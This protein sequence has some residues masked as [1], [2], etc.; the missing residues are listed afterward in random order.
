MKKQLLLLLVMGLFT[1]SA[2]AGPTVTTVNG[3]GIWQSGSGGEF[4]LAFTGFNPLSLYADV[5]KNQGSIPAGSP[6]T[7]Q[8]F[9]LEWNEHINA[10]T[11][12]DVVFNDRA[13]NGGV[14]PPGD[15]ISVGTA[16]LY[17]EF[18]NGTLS[19]YDY[20]TDAG[21]H[22]SADA[23]QKA[24]WYLEGETGGSLNAYTTLV[25][26]KFG[27][28]ADAQ[29]DNN[30]TYAVAVLNLYYAGGL[31][32]DMLVC[33]PAPGA[34]LLGGIGVMLVGWLRRRQTL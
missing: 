32:Q 4:T 1:V 2:L 12:Y 14:V 33:V 13:I 15:P 24:I 29:E 9:C 25:A 17:H 26:D 31:R 27:S 16:Y 21:R 11:T 8:T 30:G 5:A 28:V 20:Y 3:Y 10:N 18:Q 6:G 19:G 22:A 23:L 34:I 7:F